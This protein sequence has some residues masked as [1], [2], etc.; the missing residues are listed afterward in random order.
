MS[1]EEKPK[2]KQW[3]AGIEM[4]EFSGSSWRELED[5]WP[6]QVRVA[7]EAW[8]II[9]VFTPALMATQTF[10]KSMLNGKYIRSRDLFILALIQ[11][12]EE[13]RTN[14][15]TEAWPALKAMNIGGKLWY[16]RKAQLTKL[17]LIENIPAPGLRLYRVTGLGKMVIKNFVDNVEK[18][19]QDIKYWVSLQ[20]PENAE[21]VN[22]YLQANCFAEPVPKKRKKSPTK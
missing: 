18:A 7:S 15:A 5:I 17:G 6:A 4:P 14:V 9:S 19:H 13:A 1:E 20:P 12:C 8:K 22:K 16:S 11:R 3:K 10:Q 21:R 2:K